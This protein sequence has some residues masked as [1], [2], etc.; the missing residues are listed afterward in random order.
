MDLRQLEYF[1][2]VARHRHFTRAAEE[3]YVTQPALSQQVRRLERE[4][5]LELLKRTS[6]G[7]ELTPAGQELL[8]RAE[9]IL[10]DVGRARAAMDEHA[11]VTRGFVRLATAPGELLRLPAEL[12]AFHAAH[13]GMRIALRHGSAREVLE[14]LRRG[15]ADLALLA[16]ADGADAAGLEAEPL[17]DEPL[18][19]I[20]AP[21]RG[22]R[23]GR[24]GV[25]EL[26]ARPLI[27]AE[28]GTAL[29]EAVMAACQEAAS[30]RCRRSRSATQRRRASSPTRGSARASCPPRG[31][32]RRAGGLRSRA[33][34]PSRGC[35]RSCSRPP[36]ARARRPAAARTAL[37][38]AVL[39]ERLEVGDQA[40]L[41][42]RPDDLPDGR[43]VAEDH[44]GRHRRTPYWAAT[45]WLWSTS[46]F[47]TRRSSRY[48]ASSS[49][50]GLMTR[51]GRTRQPRSRR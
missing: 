11:G 23:R 9:A 17:R 5:G 44:E 45:R 22:A 13:P 51:Q 4:I 36:A 19:L 25:A 50:I 24:G 27:L 28:R 31:W 41:R 10:A 8:T 32:M 47:T 18:R 16:L 15:A 26:R 43:A 38:G 37:R 33:W 30:A 39:E 40:L 46:T 7:V 49:R 29:R 1:A 21:R 12:A 48:C 3:L 42:A 14:A 6:S 2:A 34:N 35:G 20:A